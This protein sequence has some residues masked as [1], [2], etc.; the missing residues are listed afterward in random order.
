VL[1]RRGAGSAP[2]R[3]E[4]GDVARLAGLAARRLDHEGDRGQGGL[5]RVDLDDLGPTAAA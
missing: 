2:Q 5:A 3:L 1:V 4:R